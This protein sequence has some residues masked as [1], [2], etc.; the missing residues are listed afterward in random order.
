MPTL[1]GKETDTIENKPLH[2]T[3]FLQGGHREMATT[4]IKEDELA[5]GEFPRFSKN[6]LRFSESLYWRHGSLFKDNTCYSTRIR[7]VSQQET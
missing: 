2:R 6:F 3:L 4:L 5:K 1:S 7:V